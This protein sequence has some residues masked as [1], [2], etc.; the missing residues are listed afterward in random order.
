MK[1]SKEPANDAEYSMMI[2]LKESIDERNRLQREKQVEI[3]NC[4]EDLFC[5]QL[6]MELK[7]MPSYQRCVAKQ[8]I[9]NVIFKYQMQL[10]RPNT[11]N[12]NGFQ[13]FTQDPRDPRLD[14]A[15]S[16]Y[17]FGTA[18]SEGEQNNESNDFTVL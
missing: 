1:R 3:P 9:R 11:M 16:T 15:S 14:F 13:G 17:G 7:A 8:E 6:A 4:T 2:S 5:Q 18:A 10:L 12:Y